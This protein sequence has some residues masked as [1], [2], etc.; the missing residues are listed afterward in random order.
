MAYQASASGD[1]W[2]ARVRICESGLGV[3]HVPRVAVA[4][5]S[6]SLFGLDSVDAIDAVDEKDENEDEGDLEAIL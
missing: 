4:F 2:L 3:Y 6:Q 5:G 1:K